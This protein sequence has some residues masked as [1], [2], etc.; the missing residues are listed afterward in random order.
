M[1]SS[2]QAGPWLSIIRKRAGEEGKG[3]TFKEGDCSD[4]SWKGQCKNKTCSYAHDNKSEA[5]KRKGQKGKGKER[6]EHAKGKIMKVKVKLE[7]VSKEK[8]I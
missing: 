8:K 7:R 4:L 3:F 1:L 6:K 5:T 2:N